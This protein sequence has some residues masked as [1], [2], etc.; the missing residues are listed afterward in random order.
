MH[1]ASAAMP[2]KTYNEAETFKIKF[3]DT[4]IWNTT[5]YSLG[6]LQVAQQC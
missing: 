1:T 3:K 6:S 5:A 2:D 4:L